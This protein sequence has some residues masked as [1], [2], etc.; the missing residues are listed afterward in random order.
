MKNLHLFR[1]AAAVLAVAL[2][3]GC[4]KS[5]PH[6]D[7]SV[8][9]EET[10]LHEMTFT[11]S[12]G[13]GKATRTTVSTEN[14]TKVLW[15]PKDEIKLFCQGAGAKF[16]ATNSTEAAV[17]EFTGTVTPGGSSAEDGYAYHAIY[18]YQ[19]KATFD[20]RYFSTTLDAD[21]K[22]PEGSFQDDRFI[23]IARSGDTSLAFYNVCSGLRFQVGW[24]DV[25]KV[26][27]TATAGEPV[28][29]NVCAAF[30]ETGHPAIFNISEG[31]SSITLTPE[32]GQ[33]FKPG[34]WY[35]L[36]TL[37]AKLEEGFTI[38]MTGGNTL[39]YEHTKSVSLNRGRFRSLVLTPENTCY[40]VVNAQERA[41][42][43]QARAVYSGDLDNYKT[44]IVKQFY[45]QVGSSDGQYPNP[46]RLGD[47]GWVEYATEEDF[48]DAVR[49]SG[50]TIYNVIPGVRYLYRN[51]RGEKGT[52]TAAGPLRTIR[53]EG[54]PNIRDLGGW[55]AGDMRIRYGRIYRG[56]RLDNIVNQNDILDLGVEVDLDLRGNPPGS[57]GGS[58]ESYPVKALEYA[59]IHVLMFMAAQNGQNGVTADLY[60]A[61]IRQVIQWLEQGKR[62][63]FHCHG[64]AD[65]TGT[66]AFLIETLLG[67][68]EVDANI[69][70]ELTSFSGS[71]RERTAVNYYQY[72][73]KRL[74]TY[75]KGQF[76]GATLQETVTNWATTR[77]SDTVDPLTLE[78]IG[79]LKSLLLE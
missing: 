45:R 38:S 18:P 77:H 67:V 73:F 49:V 56:G 26:T 28:A 75:L 43:Q 33:Y 37:P 76:G 34:V 14:E 11:A 27:F 9:R 54:V 39:L 64:G 65:R 31:K 78:E 32:Q 69:D 25:S 36:V 53:I 19:D 24:S 10:T 12:F 63:Y 6:S 72:P 51:D 22:S 59:N 50:S 2:T 41:F 20:G 58:G 30:D 35:Y 16:T 3:A 42:I 55:Q 40:D 57:Q 23:T 74:I 79:K 8:P 71:L 7:L 21:Q 68:S 47:A 52:F 46:I 48:S 44:T 66:L 4:T 15:S 61:S 29:G 60:Q 13:E 70:Y 62:V 17:V 5:L 1:L